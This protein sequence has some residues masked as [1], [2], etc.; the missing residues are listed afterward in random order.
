MTILSGAT[1][2][3]ALPQMAEV[4]SDQK[5][6][7]FLSKLILT[8]PALVIAILAPGAGWI[9]DRFG[10]KKLLLFSLALYAVAG[11]NGLYVNDLYLILAGRAFLGLA[12][13]GIMT[14]ISTLIA[15]FFEGAQRQRFL[16][17][18]AAIHSLSGVLFVGAGGFLA[19]ISWRM[20]F[21]LYG[22]SL[23]MLP[24]AWG[25][26]KEPEVHH[27]IQSDTT[28]P[29]TTN[30]KKIAF[31]LVTM[32]VCMIAF[33][34]VPVQLPFYMMEKLEVK[35]SLVGIAIAV[36]TITGASTASMYR[37]IKNKMSYEAIMAIG[38]FF[39]ALGYGFVSFVQEYDGIIT[40]LAITGLG[41]G[42]ILPNINLWLMDSAPVLH[43]GKLVGLLT[44]ASFGGQF[45]SPFFTEP[46]VNHFSLRDAFWYVA[47]F[48]AAFALLFLVISIK[49][50][51]SSMQTIEA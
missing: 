36:A 51:E 40:G 5:D 6:S 23:I 41:L 35:N 34:M 3:P 46:L 33:Y 50:K 14:S 11:T 2:A 28:S 47:L 38:I 10:R 49:K 9:A 31:I 39:L 44:S 1:I 45:L 16:G 19:D 27:L 8:L 26:V 25:Y 24:L 37:R 29:D 17:T 13:A 42:L 30:R 48:M 21:S 43:R 4:F 22:L 20:P 18:Q 7:V 15:D 12:V 32:V